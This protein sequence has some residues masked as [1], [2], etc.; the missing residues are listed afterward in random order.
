MG[1]GHD[2]KQD[3]KVVQVRAPKV[4]HNRT[5]WPQ[6]L[7]LSEELDAHLN[8]LTTRVIRECINDDVSEPE[9][10]SCSPKALPEPAE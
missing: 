10:R 3:R 2:A 6:F 1:G 8:E 7:A 4:F 9:A 5:L